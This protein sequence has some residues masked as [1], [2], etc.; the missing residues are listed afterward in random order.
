MKN[1]LFAL[2]LSTF[3][4]NSFASC[5]YCVHL[6]NNEVHCYVSGGSCRSNLPSHV[7]CDP[8]LA[9]A[10]QNW[11]GIIWQSDVYEI[12]VKAFDDQDLLLYDMS[13]EIDGIGHDSW[14]YWV[15]YQPSLDRAVIYVF[16]NEDAAGDI[17]DIVNEPE[18]TNVIYVNNVSEIRANGVTTIYPHPIAGNTQ[19]E[20]SYDNLPSSSVV[21][22]QVY[23]LEDQLVYDIQDADNFASYDLTTNELPDPGYYVYKVWYDGHCIASGNLIVP[24]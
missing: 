3:A 21:T 14:A 8:L 13:S 7:T 1:L 10:P 11:G 5:V 24:E 22:F 18:Y 6:A 20:F 4:G 19:V 9:N 12:H 16:A 17:E 15:D 2:L 23:D